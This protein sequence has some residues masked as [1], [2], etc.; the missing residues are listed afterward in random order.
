MLTQQRLKEFFTYDEDTGLFTR[1]KKNSNR[2][3]L[4]LSSQRVNSDGYIHIKIDGHLHKAHRAAWLY[5][6][7]KLPN[8]IIDHANRVRN[9]NR[10]SNLSD[11]TFSQNA[12]NSSLRH[13]NLSGFKGVSWHKRD[14]KFYAHI[15]VGG[16]R[17][18]LGSFSD[19]AEA[20]KSVE[21]ARL[22]C[23][24]WQVGAKMRGEV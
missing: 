3:S 14:A 15:R 10:I 7:G 2:D 6:Y 8:G 19:A 4:G 16:K 20:S 11:A 22:I 1:I 9:D 13:D 21:R 12:W 18:H 17:K 24:P 5:V 23:H